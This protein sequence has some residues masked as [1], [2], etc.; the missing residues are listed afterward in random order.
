M[1]IFFNFL[2]IRIFW[3]PK[4]NLKKI[5]KKHAAGGETVL[6]GW[7]ILREQGFNLGQ[8]FRIKTPNPEPYL[9][10]LTHTPQETIFLCLHHPRVRFQAA[11]YHSSRP[12]PCE[13]SQ[14]RQSCAVHASCVWF[15]VTPWI[16][17]R[18]VPL[19][20]GFPRQEYWV[21]ISS[22]KES[23]QPRDWTCVSCISRWIP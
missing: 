4:K 16:V 12:K 9:F 8:A 2:S 13:I 22:S 18:Q 23:S 15:S 11:R 10:C 1:Y 21:A 7:P 5:K 19:S 6:Q 20:I 14:T 3:L 17:A